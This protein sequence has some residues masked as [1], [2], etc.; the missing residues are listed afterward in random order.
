M[1]SDETNQL[2]TIATFTPLAGVKIE[3]EIERDRESKKDR[4]TRGREGG[5]E[6]SSRGTNVGRR[7]KRKGF[8]M[9]LS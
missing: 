8:D 1:R 5:E 4:A 9:R 6:L 2:M 3:R 7:L